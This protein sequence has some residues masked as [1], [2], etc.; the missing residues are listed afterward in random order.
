MN[1]TDSKVFEFLRFPL[2][3]LVIAAHIDIRDYY[4]PWTASLPIFSQSMFLFIDMFCGVAVPAFMFI[5]GF[6]FFREGKQFGRKIYFRKLNSRLH[7]ILVPYVLWNIIYFA[8]VFLLQSVSK[9]FNL[10]LHKPIAN[11]SPQDFFLL[12]WNLQDITHLSTDPIGP[13]ATQFW[14]LQCLMVLI[15]L[16]PLVWLGNRYLHILFPLII[17]VADITNV[18]PAFPGIIVNTYV[19]FVLGAFFAIQTVSPTQFAVRFRPIIYSLF[20][21]ALIVLQYSTVS[22]LFYLVDDIKNIMLILILFD[23]ASIAIRRNLTIPKLLTNSSFFIYA[24]HIF[25]TCSITFIAK[26]E[27]VP[28]RTEFS[29]ITYYLLGTVLAIVVCVLIF[30]FSDRYCKTLTSFL[31]GNRNQKI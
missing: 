10:L 28:T 13:L 2:M 3:C 8:V 29:A 24:V 11:F 22:V 9:N 4:C 27:L 7:T 23:I 5:S 1:T 17:L 16:S 20:L 15:V 19:Y 31:T 21:M 12:F 30:T 6:L 14:F 18:I 26:T 25:V